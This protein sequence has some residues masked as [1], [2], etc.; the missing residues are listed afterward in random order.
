M[1]SDN[2]AQQVEGS[3]LHREAALFMEQQDDLAKGNAFVAKNRTGLEKLS[4]PQNYDEYLNACPKLKDFMDGYRAKLVAS[5]NSAAAEAVGRPVGPLMK[6]FAA[7]FDKNFEETAYRLF[8]TLK[9]K[10]DP[11]IL[12]RLISNKNAPIFD[13][14][15]FNSINN[16]EQHHEADGQSFIYI[17]DNLTSYNELHHVFMHEFTHAFIQSF[18]PGTY[19][20]NR[21][22]NEG[23]TEELSSRILLTRTIAYFDESE[24]AAALL[25]LNPKATL[26]WYVGG[27]DE[28]FRDSLIASLEGKFP[29]EQ[30]T[31][32]AM[33][34]IYMKGD[35]ETTK[36]QLYA[37]GIKNLADALKPTNEDPD[38]RIRAEK[39]LKKF[40]IYYGGNAAPDMYS[41]V[42]NELAMDLKNPDG[43]YDIKLMDSDF[44]K[45]G[46]DRSELMVQLKMAVAP[47]ER[48]YLK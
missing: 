15:T 42:R 44:S 34:V 1:A 8:Q 24:I 19:I 5:L 41:A 36:Q 40:S 46:V 31:N 29:L 35:E 9:V 27:S 38:G 2:E 43:V 28:D 32:I 13:V 23:L 48:S 45:I 11:V 22:L 18:V 33:K 16:G 3:S 37:R 25:D 30:A 4:G 6:E 21:A 47:E 7:N 39:C 20:R 14:V 12:E 10:D 26:R 17:S